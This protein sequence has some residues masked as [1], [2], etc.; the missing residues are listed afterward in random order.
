MAGINRFCVMATLQAARAHML[1]LKL[2]EAYSWGLNRACYSEDTYVLTANGWKLHSDV[3]DTDR[4][5]VFSPR[6]DKMW[7][8]KP[9]AL[10][11]YENSGEMVHFRST[12]VDILTTPEHT[13]VYKWGSSRPWRITQ[14]KALVEKRVILPA[15]ADWDCKE[16]DMGWVEVPQ[17]LKRNGSIGPTLLSA[18]K[19]PIPTWLEL[20][21]YYLSEGGMDSKNH[22]NF[23]LAQS[24]KKPDYIDK[25][26]YILRCLPFHSHE[27]SDDTMVRWNVGNK[28]LCEYITGEFGEGHQ[29]KHIPSWIKNLPRH[30]LVILFDSLLLGDGTFRNGR[31]IRYSSTSERLAYDVA[32]IAIKLGYSTNLRVAYA[33]HG[34]RDTLYQVTLR[35]AKY[36]D[37]SK[38]KISFE[39]Y[40]GVVYCFSTSTG[41][42]VTMRN[43]KTAF[44]GNTFY[45][46]AKRGFKGGGGSGGRSKLKSAENRPPEARPDVFRLG[47]DMAFREVRGGRM[48]FT[49]GGKVQSEADF[50]RQV[51][52]RF[53]EKFSAAWRDALDLLGNYD[54][55]TL[56]SQNSFYRDVYKPNRDSLVEKWSGLVDAQVKEEKTAGRTS[57]P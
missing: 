43:G 46:A 49:I 2:D 12:L 44:Q 4:I 9:N 1:G 30:H 52:S 55:D 37:V 47:D 36:H 25:I 57:R 28:Q 26:R 42:Y 18:V 54:R 22:Y 38:Q 29:N 5:M 51:A 40:T 33:S 41:F 16:S 23:T 50:K 13:I 24:K 31:F 19:I 27:Y 17:F 10:L 15:V 56:L 3:S 53:G 34:R 7:Y 35:K 48:L 8:E 6:D 20:A 14:A 39:N 32:E 45:A 11:A 21:G